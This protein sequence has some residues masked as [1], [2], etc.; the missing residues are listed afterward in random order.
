[1][2]SAPPSRAALNRPRP[3]AVAVPARGHGALTAL[4]WRGP[5]WLEQLFNCAEHEPST[6]LVQASSAKLPW[7]AEAAQALPQGPLLQ[8]Q[9]NKASKGPWASAHRLLGSP[10]AC[11]MSSLQVVQGAGAAQV[12]CWQ[13]FEQQSLALTHDAPSTTQEAHWFW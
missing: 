13:M 2:D 4:S 11:K 8:A 9:A 1:M 6:Q 10:M 7:Q 12:P 5:Q 3:V